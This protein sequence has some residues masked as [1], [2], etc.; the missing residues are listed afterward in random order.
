MILENDNEHKKTK[1][2]LEEIAA[3]QDS[4]IQL[5]QAQLTDTLEPAKA[6]SEACQIVLQLLM[7]NTDHRRKFGN[8]EAA[9]E[10][11]AQLKRLF[12]LITQLNGLTGQLNEMKLHNR[13]LHV[14]LTQLWHLNNDLHQQLNDIKS[15]EDWK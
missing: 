14:K 11:A 13:T 4:E 6:S 12:T 8:T 10:S 9:M 1:K 2:R 5:L 7:K 3:V 15:A